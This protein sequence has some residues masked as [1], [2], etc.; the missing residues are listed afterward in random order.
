MVLSPP[1][2]PICGPSV[3]IVSRAHVARGDRVREVQSIYECLMP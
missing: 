1:F 3:E 2:L